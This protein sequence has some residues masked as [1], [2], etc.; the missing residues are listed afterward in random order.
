MRLH[1]DRFRIDCA[2]QRLEDASGA[3]PLTPK[4]FEVLRVLIER[5]DQ[6]VL[7]D[8]LL[9]AVWPDTLCSI[10]LQENARRAPRAGNDT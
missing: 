9:D 6:L 1:F 4:A 5:R 10:P 3:I 7:K 8:Q 2:N